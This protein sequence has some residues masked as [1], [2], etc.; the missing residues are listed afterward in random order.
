MAN[1]IIQDAQCLQAKTALAASPLYDLRELCVESDGDSLLISGRV[2]SFYHSQ[3][4]Q[5]AVRA[6]VR[7]VRVVNS[8]DVA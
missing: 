5:E 8:I 7:G 3:L 6:V 2:Q 1:S 4:A